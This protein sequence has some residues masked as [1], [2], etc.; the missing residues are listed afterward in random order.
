M[1]GPV[2]RLPVGSLACGDG[3][4]LRH[5]EVLVDGPVSR[6]P[7]G[8]PLCLSVRLPVYAPR[9]ACPSTHRGRPR[10]PRV[11][12]GRVLGRIMTQT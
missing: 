3:P 11:A 10:S 9:S 4:A 7:V 8:R 6:L 2:S 1:H 5:A 12:P